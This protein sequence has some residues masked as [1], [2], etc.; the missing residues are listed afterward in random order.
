MRI[1]TQ[2]GTNEAAIV[3]LGAKPS[4]MFRCDYNN[5]FLLDLQIVIV[6]SINRDE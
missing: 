4:E 5:K 1:W 3:K 6:I 2:I